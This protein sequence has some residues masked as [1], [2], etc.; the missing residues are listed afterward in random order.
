M[1]NSKSTTRTASSPPAIRREI[2]AA[3]AGALCIPTI[4]TVP[5]RIPA[6]DPLDVARPAA[7]VFKEL[8]RI[9]QALRDAPDVED[10]DPIWNTLDEAEEALVLARATT[11]EDIEA[12]LSFFRLN[13]DCLWDFGDDSVDLGKRML[14]SVVVD[15]REMM[16]GRAAR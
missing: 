12:K 16:A 13:R 14:D 3:F 15:V 8:A 11:V 6:P 9:H 2:L 5:S 4:A 10:D 1:A 7:E